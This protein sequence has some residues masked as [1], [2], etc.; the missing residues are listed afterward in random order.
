MNTVIRVLLNSNV[1]ADVSKEDKPELS[2][3]LKVEHLYFKSKMFELTVTYRTTLQY[4][5]MYHYDTVF[6]YTTSLWGKSNR[7]KNQ[8]ENLST[9]PTS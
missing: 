3:D 5:C 6:S 1:K 4:S 8:R 2:K 9:N 7:I